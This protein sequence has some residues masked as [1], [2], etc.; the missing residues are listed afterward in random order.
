[1]LQNSIACFQELLNL[2]SLRFDASV[3]L[4]SASARSRTDDWVL[5]CYFQ[6]FGE[7][8]LREA[9]QKLWKQWVRGLLTGMM[10]TR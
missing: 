6:P 2:S 9:F 1:M 8:L 4:W 3:L 10:L 7:V 5:I